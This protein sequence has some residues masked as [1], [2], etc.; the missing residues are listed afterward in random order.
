LFE[1]RYYQSITKD[2]THDVAGQSFWYLTSL[3]NYEINKS[4]NVM[5]RKRKSKNK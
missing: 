5:K 1:N 3:S 4:Y 2:P